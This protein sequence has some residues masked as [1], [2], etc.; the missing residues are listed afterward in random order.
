MNLG[1]PRCGGPGSTGRTRHLACHPGI[2][3]DRGPRVPA[4]VWPRAVGGCWWFGEQRGRES[5]HPSRPACL[6][7]WKWAREKFTRRFPWWVRAGQTGSGKCGLLSRC[8]QRLAR[9]RTRTGA[10]GGARYP[11][12]GRRR[13]RCLCVRGAPRAA[14]RL[15][16]QGGMRAGT[17]VRDRLGLPPHL[18]CG[19]LGDNAARPLIRFRGV[20]EAFESSWQ[21]E[22][23]P[24][25]K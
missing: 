25:R 8:R 24:K 5:A 16:A 15:A 1:L 17:V 9:C 22:K 2:G 23:V 4:L 3:W 19:L 21:V 18:R 10:Q 11:C 14:A 6:W 12:S 13:P 20:G 7:A